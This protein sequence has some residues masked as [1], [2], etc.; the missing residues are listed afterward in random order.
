M[1]TLKN[2]IYGTKETTTIVDKNLEIII[3]S[4]LSNPLRITY[5]DFIKTLI[6]LT[7]QKEKCMN[8]K[9]FIDDKDIIFQ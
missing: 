9:R 1:N 2:I 5:S 8:I 7:K 3:C 4:K 6:F